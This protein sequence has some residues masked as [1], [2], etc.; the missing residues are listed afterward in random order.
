MLLKKAFYITRYTLRRV[1]GFGSPVVI[2]INNKNRG[3][4]DIPTF[5]FVRFESGD[6]VQEIL[7]ARVRRNV[8][9]SANNTII[10]A[11]LLH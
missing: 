9:Q 1:A 5:A 8:L 10:I 2:R 4:P 3:S 7:S 11:A 6:V